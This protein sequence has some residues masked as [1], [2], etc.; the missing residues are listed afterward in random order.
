MAA[1]VLRQLQSAGPAAR[2]VLARALGQFGK[3]ADTVVPP[4]ITLLSDKDDAVRVGAAQALT[5]LGGK[6]KAALPKLLELAQDRSLPEAL[7][8]DAGRAVWRVDAD[9][10]KKASLPESLIKPLDFT[11]PDKR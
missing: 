10:A 1:G 2:P 5:L 6:A 8:D 7:R 4:L 11:G 3:D 9:S